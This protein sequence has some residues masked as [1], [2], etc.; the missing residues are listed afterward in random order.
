MNDSLLLEC[1][2]ETGVEG[3]ERWPQAVALY[4]QREA[5]MNDYSSTECWSSVEVR[6]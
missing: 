4:H 6:D 5:E 1:L 3:W 2:L